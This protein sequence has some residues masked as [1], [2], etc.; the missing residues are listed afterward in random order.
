MSVAETSGHK[1]HGFLEHVN[2]GRKNLRKLYKQ[3]QDH[4][5]DV[6]RTEFSNQ[7]ISFMAKAGNPA[8]H[9]YDFGT[10]TF[11]ELRPEEDQDTP[12]PSAYRDF[13]LHRVTVIAQKFVGE[14]KG[15]EESVRNYL[16]YKLGVAQHDSTEQFIAEG[17]GNF[18]TAHNRLN[19]VLT[20]LH[21][22]TFLGKK[23]KAQKRAP[24]LEVVDVPPKALEVGE[25]QKQPEKKLDADE[26]GEDA[27]LFE[28]EL[29]ATV[30]V[31]NSGNAG[32]T[33]KDDVAKR[34][35]LR[36]STIDLE[37]VSDDEDDEVYSSGSDDETS[38]GTEDE[39]EENSRATKR[40]R[41][42]SQELIQPMRDDETD[43]VGG[44]FP[45]TPPQDMD[46]DKGGSDDD[47][48]AEGVGGIPGRGPMDIDEVFDDD[49]VDDDEGMIDFRGAPRGEHELVEDDEE[50]EDVS[51]SDESS[52]EEA[53]KPKENKKYTGIVG[54]FM[55][56]GNG[57][58]NFFIS[59]YN[60][61]RKLFS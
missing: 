23:E 2:S 61:F 22:G 9:I 40:K 46:V 14:D 29:D 18:Q 50:I 34:N 39:F 41:V 38:S 53:V 49:D 6:V 51:S 37:Q 25:E 12:K 42:G 17:K 52:V 20:K 7:I 32:G 8:K 24:K 55:R 15:K 56:I 5:K 11:R 35:V 27:A 1:S 48:M 43:G 57:F 33:V 31:D 36:Q 21:D 30:L 19:K 44:G 26:S 45:F 59:I 54:F 47:E 3:D 16:L 28:E 13:L 4:L 60:W 10:H 58:E